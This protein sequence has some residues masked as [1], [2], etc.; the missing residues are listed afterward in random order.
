MRSVF[1]VFIFD[2]VDEPV[3]P[4]IIH[5]QTPDIVLWRRKTYAKAIITRSS[6]TPTRYAIRHIHFLAR[7]IPTIT[8][9]NPAHNDRFHFIARA[10][11]HFDWKNANK[12]N[13]S[14]E[15]WALCPI[16]SH[17][18]L[19]TSSHIPFPASSSPPPSLSR[20]NMLFSHIISIFAEWLDETRQECLHILIHV[21]CHRLRLIRRVLQ[22]LRFTVRC[23]MFMKLINL[24]IVSCLSAEHKSS[25][26][27]CRVCNHVTS[28]GVCGSGGASDDDGNG[29]LFLAKAA[30]NEWQGSRA[31]RIATN[32]ERKKIFW[33]SSGCVLTFLAFIAEHRRLNGRRIN[34]EF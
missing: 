23:S 24:L 15:K 16:C 4:A 25:T 3:L 30:Q 22:I 9:W 10:C 20:F 33:A 11:M 31:T 18:F 32:N 19:N 21:F 6:S 12:T 29:V 34:I 2:Y 7:N 26:S 13:E 28:S 1:V 8:W 17:I 27:S 5:H 14:N